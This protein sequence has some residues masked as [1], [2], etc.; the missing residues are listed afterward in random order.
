MSA[1][2]LARSA[3]YEIEEHDWGRLT[4]MVAGRFGN[5]DTMT[6]GQCLIR[7]GEQNPVHHHPNCDE[8]LHLLAGEIEHR[9]GD[10][11][12]PMSAGDTVSIA[13]GTVHNARNVGS[14]DAVMLISFSS[15]D[16]RTVGE[17]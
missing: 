16:R 7:P 11:Y 12:F 15:P 1:Q 4:W 6:V 5:S 13:S 10:D 3:G 2:G 8:V 17:G 9:L 14:T